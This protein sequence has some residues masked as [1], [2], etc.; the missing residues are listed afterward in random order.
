MSNKSNINGGGDKDFLDNYTTPT[1]LSLSKPYNIIEFLV[2][3]SPIFFATVVV[4]MSFMFQNFKGFIYLGFLFGIA[5]LREGIYTIVGGEKFVAN[6][7]VCS[8]VQYSNYDN[9]GFNVFIS[10]FTT[11]YMLTPMF[12]FNDY[13]YVAFGGLLVYIYVIIR[14]LMQRKCIDFGSVLMNVILGAISGIIIIT[15]LYAGGSG[16]YL[17]FNE[18]SSN[19]EVCT[20]PKK[21]TFKC[22]VYKNGEL[23]GSTAAT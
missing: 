6:G 21:Q 8:M 11:F 4:G 20:M 16:N 23:V 12:F 14:V 13:N 10:A 7:D 1:A 15:L 22:S 17:F 3:F 5:M 2:F 18:I 9:S 19:K